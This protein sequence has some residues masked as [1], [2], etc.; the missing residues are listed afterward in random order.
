MLLLGTDQGGNLRGWAY[1]LSQGRLPLRS[2]P[3]RLSASQLAPG[4]EGRRLVYANRGE[5]ASVA[6]LP[7]WACLQEAAPEHN[8]VAYRY[9]SVAVLALD[10]G[11]QVSAYEA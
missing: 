8:L 6:A 2:L 9:D 5:S 11:K 1:F 3:E 10:F 4:F 7:L